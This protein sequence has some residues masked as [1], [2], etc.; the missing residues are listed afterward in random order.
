MKTTKNSNGRLFRQRCSLKEYK[1]DLADKTSKSVPR[2]SRKTHNCKFPF[3]SRDEATR[4]FAANKR[5]KRYPHARHADACLLCTKTPF[6][7]GGKMFVTIPTLCRDLIIER[8]HQMCET[9]NKSI[10]YF[11]E[12]DD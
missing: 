12:I 1:R 8:L 4:P 7:A 9:L 10:P 11:K 3:H 2:N 6:L 5:R